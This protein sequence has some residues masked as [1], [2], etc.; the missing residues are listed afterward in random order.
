[1]CRDEVKSFFLHGVLSSLELVKEDLILLTSKMDLE[2]RPRWARNPRIA[3][4]PPRRGRNCIFRRYGVEISIKGFGCSA[5]P[6]EQKCK[7]PALIS[8]Q[9]VMLSVCQCVLAAVPFWLKFSHPSSPSITRPIHSGNGR[10][11]SKV[12]SSSSMN[13]H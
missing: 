9:F 13:R 5:S 4:P 11:S 12:T 1:M 2:S 6:Q 8:E 7:S 10:M 3:P